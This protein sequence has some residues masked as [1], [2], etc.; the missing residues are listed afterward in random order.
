MKIVTL[1]ITCFVPISILSAQPQADT[2]FLNR[3][4]ENAIRQYEVSLNN[5]SLLHNGTQYIEPTQVNEHHPFF[6]SDDWVMGTIEYDGEE[7]FNVPILYDLTGDK[8]VTES[9]NGNEIELIRDKL[10]SFTMAEHHF[11]RISNKTN[12]G[13]PRTGFYDVLYDGPHRIVALRSKSND[14]RI[15]EQTVIKDFEEKNRYFIF[16]NGRYTPANS[17]SAIVKVLVDEKAALKKY[18]KKM[19]LDFQKNR[20]YSLATLAAYYDKLSD[21]KK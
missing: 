17:R 15:S 13:L 8:V 12:N 14:Q 4:I 9:H 18:S 10:I 2:I 1:L 16:N 3:A 11:I 6:F 20:E 7:F 5:Q 21:E 19:S